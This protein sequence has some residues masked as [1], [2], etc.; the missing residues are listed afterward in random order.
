MI[1][2]LVMIVIMI[3]LLSVVAQGLSGILAS[4]IHVQ[5]AATEVMLEKLWVDAIQRSLRQPGPNEGFMAPIGSDLVDPFMTVIGHGF[6]LGLGAPLNN[7]MGLPVHYCA[8]SYEA[9][10]GTDVIAV[11]QPGL[12]YQIESMTINGV[13]Y[14][15]RTTLIPGLQR[16]SPNIVAFVISPKRAYNALSCNNIAYDAGSGIYSAPGFDAKVLP[17][18]APQVFPTIP[19]I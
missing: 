16:N 13:R 15:H 5:K 11:L 12:S 4:T 19:A 2:S 9:A 7:V 17:V 3:G 10:S 1:V 18:F 14:A 6:P 8:L